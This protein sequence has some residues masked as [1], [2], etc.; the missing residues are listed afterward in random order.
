MKQR[1]RNDKLRSNSIWVNKFTLLSKNEKQINRPL[2][3]EKESPADFHP[4]NSLNKLPEQINA[5]VVTVKTVFV[6]T[7]VEHCTF[8]R[9]HYKLVAKSAKIWKFR[10]S[11]LLLKAIV[12]SY[13][14]GLEGNATFC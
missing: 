10:P 3:L 1:K 12:G 8:S 11:E 13:D 5:A 2:L 14:F 7:L 4:K 6:K 9:C